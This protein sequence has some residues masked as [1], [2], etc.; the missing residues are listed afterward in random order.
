MVWSG[1]CQV[2]KV[3]ML[4]EFFYLPVGKQNSNLTMEFPED[5][6][7]ARIFQ[8]KFGERVIGSDEKTSLPAWE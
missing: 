1:L 7:I 3:R 4:R 6:R 5:K 2:T 8:G